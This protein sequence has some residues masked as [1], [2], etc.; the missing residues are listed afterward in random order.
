MTFAVTVAE[1]VCPAAVITLAIKFS[2]LFGLLAPEYPL[3][4]QKSAKVNVA[5]LP[6]KAADAVVPFGK[7]RITVPPLGVGSLD[8][9]VMVPVSAS[10]GVRDGLPSLIE[11]LGV[12]LAM[13]N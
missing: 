13:V 9:T 6:A 4:S 1:A 8:V 11:I 12:G 5:V 7:V 10:Q 3:G 2:V